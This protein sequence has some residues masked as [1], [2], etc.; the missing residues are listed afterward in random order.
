MEHH[1]QTE[2]CYHH[3]A[4]VKQV[5]NFLLGTKQTRQNRQAKPNNSNKPALANKNK[6][7]ET[8]PFNNKSKTLNEN[9]FHYFPLFFS[10]FSLF[11]H[12][13]SNC[14]LLTLSE[15]CTMGCMYSV[16]NF[17]YFLFQIWLCLHFNTLFQRI[18]F[19]VQSI[20][21]RRSLGH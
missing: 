11:F 15:C 10:F 12:N 14:C 3:S 1:K 18:L 8:K 13:E 20:W 6:S 16:L 21:F 5:S 19:Y 7:T 4:I 9:Y 2:A 17:V